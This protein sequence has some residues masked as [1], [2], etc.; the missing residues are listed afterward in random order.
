MRDS[1]TSDV[2]LDPDDLI[3]VDANL[4]TRF[5][6]LPI[7]GPIVLSTV[8]LCVVWLIESFDIGAIGTLVLVLEPHWNLSSSETGW[9]GASSTIGLVLGI[10]PAGRLADRFGRKRILIAGLATFSLFTLI[11]AL[12]T[13]IWMLFVFRLLAGLGEGAV[14]PIPYTMLSELVNK[15]VRGRM[16]GWLNGVLNAGYTLPALA[17]LFATSY[18]EWDVAWRI[19]LYIGGAFLLIIPVLVKWLPESPR[20]LLKRANAPGHE[21]DRQAVQNLVERLEDR[22][23]I[24]HDG[25]LIDAEAYAILRSTHDRVVSTSTLL[26]PPY[27]SRSIVSWSML[28]ASFIIW[29]TFLTYSPTFLHD[30][31]ATGNEVLLYTAIMMFISAFGIYF[32]GVAGDRWGRKPTFVVYIMLAASAMVVMPFKDALGTPAVLIAGVVAAWFGLGS[33]ALC[34]MYTAEQYPTR[35]RGLGTSTA[36]FVTRGLT[37]GILVYFLPTMFESLGTTTVF[38]LSAIT[39]VLL[40]IPLI[41]WGQETSGKN[42]EVSGTSNSGSRSGGRSGDVIRDDLHE[43]DAV[44][45]AEE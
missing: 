12:A 43:V 27:L 10:L 22:A 18:F 11:S 8:L 19:P 16:M 26:K 4:L 3:R 13:N 33:F 37:G 5:D 1:R 14:F 42:M 45:S 25:E 24:P 6:R 15:S 39:M 30:F 20:F 31:G 36:E 44:K 41:F 2:H 29:Y 40:L 9:L 21:A 32:Q 38:I 34:K 17:G 35:L 23:G 28:T 7:T